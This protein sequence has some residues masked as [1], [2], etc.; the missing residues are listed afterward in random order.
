MD[1]QELV[2]VYEALEGTTKRLAKT[3]I[4]ANLLKKTPIND[5]EEIT[6]LMQGIV[7]PKIQE[8]NL[9]VAA[10]MILK[11]ITVATGL[12]ALDV[13]KEWTKTGD[14]GIVAN[15]LIAKKKQR[16]LMSEDLTVKKVFNNLRK[17]PKIEGQG[18]VEHKI[19]LI[20]EL[21]TSAKPNEAKYI[22]RTVLEVMR[23]GVGEGSI[24]DAIL[25]AFFPKE[26]DLFFDESENKVE[27][28][29]KEVYNKLVKS[30]QSG[31]DI[32][33][34]FGIVAKLA[35]QGV[36]HLDKLK[37]QIGSPI[38]AMLALK[39]EDSKEG[40]ARVGAPCDVE[41][42]L[43]G[44]RLQCHR[45]G[46]QIK[47]FTRRLDDVTKQFPEVVEYL[48][49]YV[50]ADN[51]ILD[52]EAVGFDPKTKQYL[53]FQKV[54]QRIKR[55]HNI[56][57]IAKELPVEVN[58]FDVICYKGESLISTPFI[59]RRKILDQ[60]V[61]SHPRKIVPVKHIITESSNEV[62]KMFKKALTS[63]YEGLMLKKLD[64]PY[65]P[66]A[67]VGH[68]VKLK[69]E[70]ETLDLVIVQG[71][72]GE[73][74]RSNWITSFVL[75]CKDSE[76]FKTIGK[77][78]TGLKEKEEEGLSF[79]E[80]TGLLKPLIQKQDAKVV[81]VTPKIILEVGYEE[82]QKSPTYESGFALRFP[83]VIRDRTDKSVSEINSLSNI[84]KLYEKQ[85]K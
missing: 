35:K 16:T 29:N 78:S 49:K 10:R 56:E 1:Y 66:G 33:N 19:Q 43:D 68:M 18:S 76:S 69:G 45:A 15:N 59:E 14:L 61:E 42:K 62:E 81:T 23:V 5:L 77:V 58:V 20:A 27:Y 46:N 38:K 21:L 2:N 82:I 32:T 40:F 34:D 64:A 8:E 80:M 60:I 44:F 26:I 9:G 70:R 47:V 83:R 17:L 71:I 11:A 51:Y 84:K 30:V 48:K 13:E 6:L 65:K 36:E 79:K 63:G 54:S 57:K 67:R 55:K 37:I 75:A 39:V 12:N 4:I 3:N 41:Y 73:G 72:W 7:F 74:K 22:V 85:N 31:Y 52:S 28:K 50:K 25:W 53:P 24:R